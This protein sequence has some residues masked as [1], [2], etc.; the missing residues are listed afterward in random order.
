MFGQYFPGKRAIFRNADAEGGT[1]AGGEAGGDTTP[2]AVLWHDDDRFSAEQ[3]DWMTVKGVTTVA[4]PV[5]AVT[6]LI[7][8]GQ[9]ADRRFGRPLD[10]VIDKPGKDQPLADWRRANAEAFGLPA[11]AAGYE[12]TRPENVPE[13]MA[14]NDDLAGKMRDLAFARGLAPDDVRAMTEMYAGYVTEAAGALD[15]EMHQAET[16]LEGE[17]QKLWGKDTEA[18]KTR[19]RQAAGALA[20]AAGLD[21]DGVKAVVGLLSGGEPGQTLALRMF[22]ALGEMMGEDRAIG[23]KHG[24]SALTMTKD[25]ATAEFT[26]FMAPDGDWAK[27]SKAG[28]SETIARLRPQFERL[29]RLAAGTK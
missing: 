11:D 2:P 7:G 25:E 3:R 10:Q 24:T 18:N 12:I 22:A 16:A 14:W 8:M 29:A 28:D 20:E 4:D 19:A 21:G 9:A 26:K 17:L 1:G 5:E 23:L 27:A 6:K 15:Q 13:G